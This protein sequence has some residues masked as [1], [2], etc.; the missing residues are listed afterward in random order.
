MKKILFTTLCMALAGNAFSQIVIEA[1]DMPN[2]G[3]TFRIGTVKLFSTETLEAYPTVFSADTGANKTW[4]FTFMTPTTESIQKYQTALQVSPIYALGISPNAYGYKVLD[5]LPIP[6][7][8]LPVSIT[9]IYSFFEKQTNPDRFSSVALGVTAAGFP[10]PAVYSDPDEI[11]WLPLIYQD[12]NSSTFKTGFALPNVFGLVQKG[13]RT[14]TMDSWGT[15]K[16]PY[17]QTP[18]NCLRVRSVINEVD[19]LTLD[20][21][22]IPIP[23]TSIEYKWMVK[24][25]HYP[26]VQINTSVIL[27]IELITNIQ[28]LDSTSTTAVS[29]IPAKTTQVLTAHPNPMEDGVTELDVPASWNNYMVSVFD[30]NGKMLQ[31]SINQDT[32]NLKHLA[33]GQYIV[34]VTSENSTGYVKI[35]R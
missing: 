6:D 27:G 3:E 29:N 21:I 25:I 8:I 18:Q 31:N 22:T 33:K 35:I 11:Y 30:M 15:V 10:I 20:S 19:T 12:V 14:T 13:T 1:Q 16:T 17:I 23:R 4:D 26:V 24:G 7:S 2:A 28:F 34:R 9:N 32:L 5:T